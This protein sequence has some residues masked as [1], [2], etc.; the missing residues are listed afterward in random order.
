MICRVFPRRTKWTPT[1]P[2]AFVGYPPLIRSEADCVMVSCTFTWDI[3]EARRL[4]RAWAQYYPTLLGGPAI[5][6]VESYAGPGIPLPPPPDPRIGFVPGRFISPGVTFTTRGCNK[7]CPWCLVPERE[8][9]LQTIE[10]FAEGP[11]IQDNNFLLA[12]PSHRVR[13]AAHRRP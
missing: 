10:N 7:A 11:V 3:P 13:I 5:Q 6:G 8:G 2:L 4:A 12:P 9:K 1:D